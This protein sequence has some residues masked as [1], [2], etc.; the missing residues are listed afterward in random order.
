MRILILSSAIEDLLEGYKFYESQA[1]GLGEYFL[2]SLISD[3]NH[4]SYMGVFI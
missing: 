3:F 4:L 2:E 1:K